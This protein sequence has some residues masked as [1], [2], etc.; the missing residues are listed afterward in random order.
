MTT[1][2]RYMTHAERAKRRGAIKRELAAGL[3]PAEVAAKFGVSRPHV[4]QIAKAA[5]VATRSPGRPRSIPYEGETLRR[6]ANWRKRFGAQLARQMI[7][8]QP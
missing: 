7:E 6:Y 4:C 5:G 1:P 3:A 2:A 8:T